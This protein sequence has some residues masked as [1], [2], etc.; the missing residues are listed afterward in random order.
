METIMNEFAKK[1]EIDIKGW[2]SAMTKSIKFLGH[3]IKQCPNERFIDVDQDHYIKENV[4]EIL[5]Q[6]TKNRRT[7][8]DTTPCTKE[9]LK[10]LQGGN[11]TGIWVISQT[12]ADVA[13]QVSMVAG[14]VGRNP[15]IS[16]IKNFDKAVACMRSRKV[17]IRYK[18]LGKDCEDFELLCYHD[19]SFGN[20]PKGGSQGGIILFAIPRG[21]VAQEDFY[22]PQGK[23]VPCAPLYWKSF[24]LQRVAR[25][26][27]CGETLCASEALDVGQHHR[28]FLSTLMSRH[29]PVSQVTDCKSLKDNVDS[30]V[31]K[32][33]E[34]RLRRDLHAIHEAVLNKE[35]AAFM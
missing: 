33:T 23:T 7:M 17:T 35:L 5:P 24:R 15:T 4:K 13:V 2:D 16:T 27:F 28:E 29:I 31:P 20:L 34:K 1:F 25:S 6:I 8:P 30:I 3:D 19:A 11:G 21:Q 18:R 10:L 32:S 26:T 9:E 22:N 14:E 12:R